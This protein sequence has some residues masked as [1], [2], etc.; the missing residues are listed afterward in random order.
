MN[1]RRLFKMLVASPLLKLVPVEESS[2][3]KYIGDLL[4]PGETVFTSIPQWYL[5]T[6]H[7]TID[8][9]ENLATRSECMMCKPEFAF[10]WQG[11]ITIDPATKTSSI[12]MSRDPIR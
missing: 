6:L 4:D 12:E 10:R 5:D 2:R 7:R 3:Y 1:R 8:Q 11:T 9:W